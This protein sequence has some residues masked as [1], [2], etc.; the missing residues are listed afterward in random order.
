VAETAAI[1]AEALVGSGRGVSV[2]AVLT[3]VLA[4]TQIAPKRGW[5]VVHKCSTADP[6]PGRITRCA[7]LKL[8]GCQMCNGGELPVMPRTGRSIVR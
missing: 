2:A 1:R 8:L 7:Q 4:R 5:K 6:A 3:D